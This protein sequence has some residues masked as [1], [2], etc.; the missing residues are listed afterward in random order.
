[1]IDIL[2]KPWYDLVGGEFNKQYMHDLAAYVS[3]ERKQYI[4]Y[5]KNTRD[6]FAVFRNTPVNSIKAVVVSQDPYHDGSYANMAFSNRD[7][8][9]PISP[10]LRN[11][12]K[13]VEDDI[14]DG[15]QVD[16]NPDLTRWQQQGVFLINRVLTVR[17]KQPDSHAGRGWEQ[18]TEK[19]IY[20]LSKRGNVVFMLWGSKAKAL[21][22]IIV[23]EKN[24]VL[25]SGHPSPLSANRGLWFGNKHFSQANT[26]LESNN[27][28]TINW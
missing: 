27:I 20:E 7:D 22:P 9:Q 14:Y 2:G 11:I 5:P 28:K 12:L 8:G 19:C 15:L 1:M 4:V 13:E 16:Q 17:R 23:E 24:L 26:F 18:F 21:R 6:V 3:A 10:S 25:T